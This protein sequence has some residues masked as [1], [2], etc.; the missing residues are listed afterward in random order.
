[1]SQPQPVEYYVQPAASYDDGY[2]KALAICHYVWGG[3][4]LLFS[5]IFI[6]H[7]VM[8]AM[9]LNGT[10]PG[11]AGG[12][13]PPKE[14]GYMFIGMGGCGMFMGWAMG[15]LTIVSGRCINPP[16]HSIPKPSALA[17]VKLTIMEPIK[18]IKAIKEETK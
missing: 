17:R 11:G 18:P 16:L 10:F 2:L 3:L 6:V 14:M 1:M 5:S 4:T 9:V 12:P 13:P 8:G 7:I 15:I